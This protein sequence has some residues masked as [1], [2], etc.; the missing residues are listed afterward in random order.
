[1]WLALDVDDL[2]LLAAPPRSPTSPIGVWLGVF[3][4]LWV[5]NAIASVERQSASCLEVVAA[6]NGPSPAAERSLRSWQQVSRHSITIAVNDRNR[7]PIGS[8]YATRHLLRTPW[9]APMHQDDTYRS[10]HIATLGSSAAA[11]ADDVIAVF[12]AM[13]GIGD[14]GTPRAA[15]PVRNRHLD[16]AP[17]WETLPEIIR[18]HPLP[19]PAS[20]IRNPAG[21]V[22]GL[23]WYDSGAPDSE[24]FA[25]LACRGRFR[26]LGDI[27]VQYRQPATS[28]SSQTGRES[29]AWQWAQSLGRFVQS[30]DFSSFLSNVPA[31]HRERAACDILAGIPARYPESPAF[32]FLQFAA[33]QAMAEAWGYSS[34]PAADV[35]L[36]FLAA[37]GE[38]AA[39][40]NLR[41]IVGSH[42]SVVP[43]S[44]ELSSLIGVPPKSGSVDRIGR[45]LYRRHGHRLPQWAQ[46]AAFSAYDRL[47]PRRGAQ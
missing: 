16:L 24:W 44:A 14:D 17:S 36:N 29:R 25:H 26:I 33:A 43:R 27:T 3:G 13:T 8:W 32:S 21:Q 4:D 5:D 42:H 20:A 2:R 38:S 35:L 7:G 34:G 12:T 1:M 37:G 19:T 31:V 40:R 30:Q 6:L 47:R 23:A 10:S 9:V 45:N 41:S 18:R 28:E 46:Q 22:E 11:A 15:P 39:S